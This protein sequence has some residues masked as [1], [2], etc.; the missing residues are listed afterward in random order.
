LLFTVFRSVNPNE[1]TLRAVAWHAPLAGGPAAAL[2]DVTDAASA[3][4]TA[5]AL[6]LLLIALLM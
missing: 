5:L 1:R 6:A 3:L 4:S 2:D